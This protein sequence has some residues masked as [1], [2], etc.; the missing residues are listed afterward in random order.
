MLLDRFGSI[1]NIMNASAD[2]LNAALPD[3]P[4]VA[5]ALV[6]CQKLARL[7][8]LEQLVSAPVDLGDPRLRNYLIAELQNPSEERL[9]AIYLDRDHRYIRDERVAQG[10]R[11]NLVLRLRYL[12]HRTLDLDAAGLIVA[13]NH[14]SGSAEPSAADHDATDRLRRLTAQLDIRLVDHCIVARGRV[15]S[16][17]LGKL[18]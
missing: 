16:M 11:D 9:H 14:P 8:A 17:A 12:V 4:D 6:A 1:A 15:F 18:I 2:T 7:G 5:K 3:E 13:H 10:S